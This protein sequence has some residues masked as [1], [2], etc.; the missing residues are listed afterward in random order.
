MNSNSNYE[1]MKPSEFKETNRTI[2]IY[3]N[4]YM[5]QIKSISRKLVNLKRHSYRTCINETGL[6]QDLHSEK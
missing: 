6:I 1:N 5:K 4:I 3:E 2:Y